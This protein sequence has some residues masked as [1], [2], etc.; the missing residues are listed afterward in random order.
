MSSTKPKIA[1]FDFAGCEGCQLTVIDSLQN[2][3]DLLSAV[4]IVQF[5]EAMSERSDDYQIAI[6]EGSYTRPS[7]EVR[8]RAIRD[9]AQIVVALGACAHLGGVNAIRNAHR[10]DEIRSYVYG[11]NAEVYEAAA[12]RPISDVIQV[13]AFIPGCPIDTGEFVRA[14]KSLLQGNAPDIPDYPVCV[15]CKLRETGCVFL[16]GK[17]CLGPITRAGCGAICPSFGVGCEGCRGLIPNPNIFSLREV[18]S[19]NGLDE[20]SI[21]AK[22]GLFLTNQIATCDTEA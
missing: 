14:V 3:T 12:A 18:L 17:T 21:Q 22:M 16:Y 10:L 2:H 6:V 15:E 13:D 4:E 5:R 19:E 9:Q 11:E 1:F 8:L 7:D 20:L